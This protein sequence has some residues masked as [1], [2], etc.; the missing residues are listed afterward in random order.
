MSIL[1]KLFQKDSDSLNS[2]KA[3]KIT[4]KKMEYPSK[5]ILAWTEALKGNLEIAKWLNENGYEELV[6]ANLAIKLNQLSRN[7]LMDNGYPHIMAFINAAEGDEN[8]KKWLLKYRFELL[9]HLA[10]Y[11]DGENESNNWIQKNASPEFIYLAKII[12]DIKDKI[13][14]NHNDIHSFRKDL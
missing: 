14:E 13:E 8:A 1:K 2:S 12:K 9:W 4:I 3:T 11:I 6:H 7:W 10:I 5:I